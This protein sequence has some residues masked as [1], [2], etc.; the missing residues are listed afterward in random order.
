MR[1]TIIRQLY[2]MYLYLDGGFAITYQII[3]HAPPAC[4][5]PLPGH[6]ASRRFSVG[7][8]SIISLL[9]PSGSGKG[10]VHGRGIFGVFP[11]FTASGQR[12]AGNYRYSKRTIAGSFTILSLGRRTTLTCGSDDTWAACG[13]RGSAGSLIYQEA[14]DLIPTTYLST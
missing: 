7:L 4:I 11:I 12:R 6:A 14:R 9:R 13:I 10:V 2:N 5:P 3:L 1:K 8:A